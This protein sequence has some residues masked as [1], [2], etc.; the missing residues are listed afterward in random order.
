MFGLAFLGHGPFCETDERFLS[1]G[2][3][4]ASIVSFLSC[5]IEMQD[6]EIEECE[7]EY[8][9]YWNQTKVDQRI[10]DVS[11]RLRHQGYGVGAP[12]SRTTV[13][14]KVR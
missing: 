7:F 8:S 9:L 10:L 13:G 6:I 12:V 14:S 1:K 5:K 2:A 3:T 11:L 4:F